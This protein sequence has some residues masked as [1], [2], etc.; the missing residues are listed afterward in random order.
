[1]NELLDLILLDE[2]KARKNKSD[3]KNK[4]LL[5][6]SNPLL[7][8]EE[9]L[10]I[11]P[12]KI[13]WSL[14]PEY[15]NHRWDGTPNPFKKILDCLVASKW[16]GV[17][18]ATGTG[19]TF[20]AALIALWF[21]ECWENSTVVTTAPKQ[22]QLDLHL[23]KELSSL[24]GRFGKGEMQKL[25]IRMIP[26]SEEWL[27]VGFVAGT[28]ADEESATKA[29]GFHNKNMLIILEEMTG[30]NQAVINAFQTTCTSP[31]NLILGLGNPDHR[32]D[33]LHRFCE[34]SGVEHIRISG[35]DHPNIVLNNPTYING[36]ISRAGIE[37]IKLRFGVDNPM[38]L[39]RTRGISPAESSDSLIK[40]EW[41]IKAIER[42]EAMDVDK[43][44]GNLG[45]GCD[46]ANS[47]AGD[48]SCIAK[49]KGNVLISLEDEAC[50][51]SNQLGHRIALMIEQEGIDPINVGVD[52]IGVG[53]G[54]VNTLKE[55]GYTQENINIQS[56]GKPEQGDD[57]EKFINL[58]AQ[59]YW[60]LREDLRLGVISLLRDEEMIA[61]LIMP[62]YKVNN[63]KIAIESKDEIK[64]RL[65]R[66][67][68]KADAIVYWNWVRSNEDSIGNILTYRKQDSSNIL[69]G[70]D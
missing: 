30:I 8:Y 10:G 62:K 50:P 4:T 70:Y 38:T 66:S 32:L 27:L 46:V 34:Q 36:A 64:K 19:K 24:Y 67:P 43:I 26:N 23:W 12:K 16:V 44:S 17:E 61:E 7:Y 48:K 41:I 15:S 42:Y 49:G 20:N 65:G 47:E 31:H 35:Y 22:A 13:D 37:R 58:R 69:R 52:G 25:K 59:M 5:Y 40:L 53:A 39:S 14:I 51:D 6:Q 9:R 68:N 18:S 1:M 21:L 63:G 60:R 3:N 33:T 28:K 2:L 54:T 57:V 45:L 29:Q 56:G 11:D 55:Y